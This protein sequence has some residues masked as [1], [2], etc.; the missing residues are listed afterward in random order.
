MEEKEVS[1]R[2]GSIA[3]ECKKNLSL[4][5]ERG[6]SH[7]QGTTPNVRAGSGG[8]SRQGYRHKKRMTSGKQEKQVDRL[9]FKGSREGRRQE[10]SGSKRTEGKG[11]K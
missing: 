11:R 4:L 10:T 7:G 5:E 8:G 1:L 9:D 2:D 6:C 3:E